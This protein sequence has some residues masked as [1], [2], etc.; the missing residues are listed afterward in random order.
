MTRIHDDRSRAVAWAWTRFILGM[1]QMAAA[2]VSVVLL[3]DLGVA[4]VSL[5]AVVATCHYPRLARCYLA[6]VEGAE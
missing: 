3:L 1:A 6:A 2:V 4:T 5:I